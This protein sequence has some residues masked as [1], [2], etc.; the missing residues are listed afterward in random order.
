MRFEGLI[1]AWAAL[2]LS[3][4]AQDVGRF[5]NRPNTIVV[6]ASGK[7]ETAPDFATIALTI[8]GQ[9]KTPDAATTALAAKQTAIF[10]G[11]RRLDPKA[12]VRIGCA[13]RSAQGRVRQSRL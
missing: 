7:I 12:E 11:L 1:L 4:P 3:A 8:R 13:A 10:E 6:S 2:P 5:P 9:G